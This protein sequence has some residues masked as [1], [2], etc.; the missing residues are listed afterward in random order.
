[1]WILAGASRGAAR[2]GH[3]D[4]FDLW[5]LIGL[6]YLGA[7]LVALGFGLI[8]FAGPSNTVLA[9]VAV[10]LL[11][12]A[13]LFLI[14]V[15]IALGASV[16]KTAHYYA[17]LLAAR[18]LGEER[19][20]KLESYRA[21]LGS[22]GALALFLAAASPIPDE[23]VVIPLSLMGY[24]IG[25]F[26]LAFFAGKMVATL[27][28]AYSGQAVFPALRSLFDTVGTAVLSVILTVAV[29]LTMLRMKKRKVHLPSREALSRIEAAPHLSRSS[30][31]SC[32]NN[33]RVNLVSRL[34]H[35]AIPRINTTVFLEI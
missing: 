32:R 33:P 25:R 13:H 17:T 19:R 26:F 28:G 7:F 29:T 14:A 22:S 15:T 30:L 10:M 6:G 27:L 9:A 35:T 34:H 4:L 31:S 8:P 3:A 24:N 12:S 21:R 16:A 2:G 11:S 18:A 20:K 5:S 23:P 1:M